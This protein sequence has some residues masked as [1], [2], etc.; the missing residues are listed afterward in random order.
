MAT[1]TA[2]NRSEAV[3]AADRDA[4]WAV[5]T[6]PDLLVQLTPLLTRID[7]D[8]DRW[9][10]HLMRITALGVGIAP[11]FT[12]Q[13]TFTPTTQIRFHHVSPAGSREHA[14][15]EGHYELTDAPHGTHLAVEL[16]MAVDLP[17]PRLS[18]PAVERV[19]SLTMARTGERFSANLL[20]HLGLKS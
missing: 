18:A 6:D 3:V 2:T 13:M 1:F 11:V 4:I 20:R 5:L 16:T 14:G 19:M 9:T 8:G 12:E 15:V 17:L 7:A 10:W